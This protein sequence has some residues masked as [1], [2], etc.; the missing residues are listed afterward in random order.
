M[1][2]VESILN[3]HSILSFTRESARKAAEKGAELKDKGIQI[4]VR[5]LFNASIC[6]V[7]KMPI[8]TKNKTHYERIKDLTVLTP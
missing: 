1:I 4:E 2:E 6:L 8:L 7:R 5:D 3:Q